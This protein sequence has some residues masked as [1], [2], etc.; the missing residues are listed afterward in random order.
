MKTFHRRPVE[1]LELIPARIV[2]HR[3]YDEVVAC[4]GCDAIV[5]APAPPTLLDG[6]LLGPTLVTEAVCAKVL[7]GTPIERQARNYQQ[8]RGPGCGEHPGARR[9]N[10]LGLMVPLADR[11]M[12][13]VKRAEQLQF[14]ATS[15]KVL[16]R[17]SAD[18]RH[19][20]HALGVHRRREVDGL[21]AL[22][23]RRQ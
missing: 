16:D 12:E 2:V 8:G 1:T 23:D 4:D 13:R 14:D 7:D 9:G 20:R 10:L 15:L 5:C 22:H 21:H 11:V 18:G 6:G 19:P 3:R 17:Q